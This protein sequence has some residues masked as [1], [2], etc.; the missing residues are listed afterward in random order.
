VSVSVN[1]NWN[2]VK[3]FR[4]YEFQDPLHGPESGDLIDD[5]LVV[6]LDRLRHE[7][8]WP[9]IIHWA[10]GGAVDVDGTYGHADHSFHLASMGCKAVDFHFQTDAP[11]R[12]QYYLVSKVGFAGVGI[13]P[14]WKPC[15]GF[16]V[17]LRPMVQTQRWSYRNG[18]YW[19]LLP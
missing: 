5:R 10:V 19:Y 15:A 8:G 12:Y 4:R 7:A 1:V 18:E 13:Y 11:F 17:D 16:H 14:D 3:Y 2:R 6:M 9:I